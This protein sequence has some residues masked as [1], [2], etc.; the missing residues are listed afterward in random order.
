MITGCKNNG[1]KGYALSSFRRH[2]HSHKTVLLKSAKE[3]EKV[4]K[5][6]QNYENQV[7]CKGCCMLVAYTN[8]KWLCKSCA[9]LDEVGQVSLGLSNIERDFIISN[10]RA[11]NRF[12]LR[13]LTE[14]PNS[15][16]RLWSD[17]V[18]ATLLK[19]ERAKTDK[20]SFLAL[21][22]WVKL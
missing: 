15:L 22:S 2:I 8:S 5:E 16:R 1:G 4:T 17:C 20:D 6:L 12:H 11:A 10:I 14:I 9:S 3:R 21:E 7:L 18:T 13:I 19:F